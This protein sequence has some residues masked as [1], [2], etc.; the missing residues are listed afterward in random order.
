MFPKLVTISIPEFLQGFLPAH[1]TLHSYGLMIALGVVAA[2]FISL[3]KT[4]KFGM[5]A[6]KLSSLFVWVILAAFIGGKL[7]FFM[8]DIGKYIADPSLLKRALG[9]GFVFYGSLI[10]AIPTIVLWLRKNKIAV[11]PFLDVL[12]FAGPVV[13]SFGRVGCFLAGCCHGKVCSS[14]LGVTFSNPDSLAAIKNVPLYP[15]QLFDI[16]VNLF[17]LFTI[18]LVQKK[19]K[20]DGQLF[21]IYLMMYGVGR[22]IV[23]LFRGDEARGFLFG[24][25]LSHSQFIAIIIII[26]SLFVW[27]KWSKN[28]ELA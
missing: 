20:F 16:L 26:I 2:F 7:F 4:K 9:G 15:T 23:E 19:Q 24:G 8:E 17:I 14:W 1:F 11:R 27:R 13:H 12:S 21:L 28:T 5:D 10:F 25:A 18:Y 6:D 22:S 3:R